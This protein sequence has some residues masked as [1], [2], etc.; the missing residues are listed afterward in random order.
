MGINRCLERLRQRYYWPGM[1]TEVQLWTA[2]CEKCNR[3]KIPRPISKGTNAEHRRWTTGG[4]VG[5]GRIRS[6]SYDCTGEPVHL[7]YVRSL[8][9]VGR[10]GAN[11]Q[12]TSRD[13][14]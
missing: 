4:T 9:Q 2:E 3:R 8:H 13:G 12:S 14:S 5:Y 7:G 10:G 11:A 1:A 6:T